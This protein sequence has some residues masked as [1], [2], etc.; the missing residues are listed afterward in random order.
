[1]RP[2]ARKQARIHSAGLDGVA[3]DAA[4]GGIEK[5]IPAFAEI[6]LKQFILHFHLFI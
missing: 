6:L 1:L 4:R 2:D 3:L 5:V